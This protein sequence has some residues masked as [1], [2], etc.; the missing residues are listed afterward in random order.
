MRFFCFF[1]WKK[2]EAGVWG[3]ERLKHANLVGG[4]LLRASQYFFDNIARLILIPIPSTVTQRHQFLLS[5]SAHEDWVKTP[6]RKQERHPF[7]QRNLH[8]PQKHCSQQATKAI[9]KWPQMACA[10]KLCFSRFLPL[11]PLFGE[12]MCAKRTCRPLQGNFTTFQTL[13]SSLVAF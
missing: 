1:V 11:P 13:K 6:Q 8:D 7:F 3:L 10:E 9:Q 4:F 12:N 2:K 5:I